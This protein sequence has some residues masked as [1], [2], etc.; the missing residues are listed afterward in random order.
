MPA[1]VI[2]VV[3][4]RQIFPEIS[5]RH[6]CKTYEH[7]RKEKETRGEGEEKEEDD[8]EKPKRAEEKRREKERQITK[9]KKKRGTRAAALR[10]VSL[11]EFFQFSRDHKGFVAGSPSPVER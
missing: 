8:D 11:F 1:S 2:V 10:F 9:K 6:L 5:P 4:R 7:E 3:H